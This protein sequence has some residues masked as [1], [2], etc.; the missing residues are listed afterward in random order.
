MAGCPE[1]DGMLL[2]LDDVSGPEAKSVADVL[3][4]ESDGT[5]T[6]TAYEPAIPIELVEHLIA[7]ARVRLP[8]EEPPGP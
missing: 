2:E 6:F 5:M 1:P 8:P 4:L 3:Y 7:Q